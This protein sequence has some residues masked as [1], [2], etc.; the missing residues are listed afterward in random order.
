M[1]HVEQ[2]EIKE[3]N[4]KDEGILLLKEYERLQINEALGPTNMW[5]AGQKLEHKPTEEEAVMYYYDNGGADDFRRRNGNR[6][7]GREKDKKKKDD[8]QAAQR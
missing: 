8:K 1:R 2:P 3:N 5:F 7:A 4:Q 6:L